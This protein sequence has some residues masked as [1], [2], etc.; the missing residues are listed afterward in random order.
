M[1]GKHHATELLNYTLS[2]NGLLLFIYA[3]FLNLSSGFVEL[4]AFGKV[5]SSLGLF[6]SICQRRGLG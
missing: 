3:L 4:G 2:A 6:F 5:S 1:L